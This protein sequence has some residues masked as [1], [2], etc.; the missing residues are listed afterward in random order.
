ME[1]PSNPSPASQKLT[2]IT[3]DYIFI[4]IMLT[5]LASV[6]WIGILSFEEAM[7]TEESKR[8][9]EELATWL[10][11]AGTKR[12]APDYALAA[13]AGGVKAAA[14]EH[15]HAALSP[16][17]LD[18]SAIGMEQEQSA[19]S[20]EAE[21]EKAAAPTASTWG[22]CLEKMFTLPEFAKM[23]NP[24]TKERP[25]FVPACVPTDS[26]LPG[27]IFI[28]KLVATPPGSSVP[29][30][31]SPL[32]ETDAIGEKVQLRLAICDKG[33]YAVKIAEFDF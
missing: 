33:S 18:E 20:G 12:F 15:A 9:G 28:E 16:A 10:T 3:A 25:R 13:C 2:L 24:F 6:I 11:E 31:N 30:V 21:K 17:A 22:A 8:N 5:V 19:K 14:A 29:Y 1:A 23:V 26:D 32:V 7:K 27:A 4:S